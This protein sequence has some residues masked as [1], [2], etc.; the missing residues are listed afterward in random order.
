MQD[1]PNGLYGCSKTLTLI[2]DALAAHM[3][4]LFKADFPL[5][6]ST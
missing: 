1:S 3:L 6:T 2:S 5:I 4:T